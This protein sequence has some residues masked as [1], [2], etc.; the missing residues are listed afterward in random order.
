MNVDLGFYL[1]CSNQIYA[2]SCDRCDAYSN[3]WCIRI[4]EKEFL[5]D[6]SLF[7]RLIGKFWCG[8]NGNFRCVV[9]WCCVISGVK[10]HA[11]M[12]YV[13]QKK[14]MGFCVCVM[15]KLYTSIHDIVL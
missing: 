8:S 6:V 11:C 2:H 10:I 3:L 7:R 1:G 13:K 15:L 5:L 14:N 4:K 9:W 12:I